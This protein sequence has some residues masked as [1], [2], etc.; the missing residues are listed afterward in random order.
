MTKDFPRS[1]L[2]QSYSIS[3]VLKGGWQLSEGHSQMID[4]QQAI[5]D[6]RT[7][8]AAGITTFDCADIY[9][10]VEVLIGKFLKKYKSTIDSGELPAVQV[11][12]KCVPDLDEL[13]TFTK[14][15]TEALIDRSL[16]RMGVER[17]D[18][19][20]FSWWDLSIPGYLDLAQYLAES[21]TAGKIR[22]VG[23]T[24]FDA[25]HLKEIL[26]VG[27]QVVS[28]QVQYSVLDQRPEA[29]ISELCRQHDIKLLCYGTIAGG[30]LTERYLG[31]IEPHEP[32][33]NRSLTKYKLVIDEFGGW[34]L[35][36]ELLVSLKAAADKHRVGIAEVAVK[37]IL[38]K[39]LVAGAIVGAQNSRHIERIKQLK[40]FELDQQDLEDINAIISKSQGPKGSVYDM[41]RQKDSKHAK[42]MRYNQNKLAEADKNT[43]GI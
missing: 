23:V 10:G 31:A 25:V 28:N 43:A 42:I 9:T 13:P 18:L 8:V 41:E 16:S 12:T 29:D 33:E 2:T 6:M 15:K 24:N 27:V 32:L 40:T 3:Q 37:Y 17:L 4:E 22:Y 39:Q 7:F 20:Q 36:Q 21:Q 1:D 5:E 35:F 19:V 26:D 30:F 38:Q 34:D 14:A 11:H